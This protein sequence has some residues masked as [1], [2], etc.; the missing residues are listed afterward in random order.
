MQT[1]RSGQFGAAAAS[2]LAAK[3]ATTKAGRVAAREAATEQALGA[4]NLSLFVTL[5]GFGTGMCC[6][7]VFTACGGSP[8]WEH[9]LDLISGRER[10]TL[11]RGLVVDDFDLDEYAGVT[12]E[13]E[14]EEGVEKTE[15][16]RRRNGG[17]RRKTKRSKQD[18]SL[19]APMVISPASSRFGHSETTAVA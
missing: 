15:A 7:A 17:N 6:V 1:A 5:L 4:N 10:R 19:G 18:G 13:Q 14:R 12:D 16:D 8:V 11:P 2:R 3:G 9:L